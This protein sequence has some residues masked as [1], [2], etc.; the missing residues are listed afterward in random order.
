MICLKC[1]DLR[2]DRLHFLHEQ[3]ALFAFF[4]PEIPFVFHR[5]PTKLFCPDAQV[6][7]LFLHSAFRQSSLGGVGKDVRGYLARIAYPKNPDTCRDE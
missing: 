1:A 2:P 3:V 7:D 4:L 5:H 6:L